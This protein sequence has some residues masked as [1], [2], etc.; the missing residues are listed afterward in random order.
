MCVNDSC[1]TIAPAS[2]GFA[3]DAAAEIQSAALPIVVA[4]ELQMVLCGS[5]ATKVWLGFLAVGRL[6]VDWMDLR[7][8][9]S[10]MI[11]AWTAVD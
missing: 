6:G 1:W 10:A 11:A 3:A 5:W 4:S 2:L 8:E 9:Q 7:R